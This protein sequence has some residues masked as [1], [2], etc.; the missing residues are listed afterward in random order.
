[1]G[2]ARQVA[3]RI[4]GTVAFR[5]LAITG[6]FAAALSMAGAADA[7]ATE[8]LRVG[9]P[10]ADAFSF[11]P[12]DV[13]LKFGIFQKYGID[14]ERTSLG[15]SAKLHQAMTAGALDIGVG[16]GSDLAFL[17]KGAPEIAVAAM[18]G[19]PLIF[20][21]NVRYDAPYKTPADLKDARFG[22]STAGSL[23][24]WF[25]FRLAQQQGW[26]PGD[27][28]LATLGADRLADTAALLSHQVDVLPNSASLGFALEEQKK[29]RMLFPASDLVHDFLLHAIFASDP[30][31]K[32]H[33]D[34]IRAF[35]KGWFETIA[36]M[37]QH[38]P[39]TVDAERARSH[40][41]DSVEAHEYDLVMPMFSS[42]GKFE[43]Q[44]LA[45]L[46]DSFADTKILPTKPNLSKYYTEQF[47]PLN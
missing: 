23:G 46:A 16:A 17:V 39:E 3:A 12:L 30:M 22:V 4:A 8:K 21:F 5:H 25:V 9:D 33:P 7:R 35:L 32:A 6:L 1:M 41:S 27:Y 24:E 29:G 38:K 14:F 42:T 2:Q 26:S 44:A 31:V 13:G 18:A 40:Y 28:Q 20:G 15:G 45:V 19:P 11:I 10:A 34:Q 47:L 43:P 37:R 36:F